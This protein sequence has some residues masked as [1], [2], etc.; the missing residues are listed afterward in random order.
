MVGINHVCFLIMKLSEQQKTLIELIRKHSD[1]AGWCAMTEIIS[2][3][4]GS[5]KTRNSFYRSLT[6]LESRGFLERRHEIIGQGP[7][8]RGFVRLTEKTNNLG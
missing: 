4:N 1:E 5:H 8:Y 2:Y 3:S 7:S 6:R